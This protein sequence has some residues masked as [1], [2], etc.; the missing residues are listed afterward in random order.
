[1]DFEQNLGFKWFGRRT[2]WFRNDGAR[3]FSKK[4]LSKIGYLSGFILAQARADCLCVR[5]E[6]LY[7]LCATT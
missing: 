1:M 6:H 5:H 4:M 3:I 2:V 7:S